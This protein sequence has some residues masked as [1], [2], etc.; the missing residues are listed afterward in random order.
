M[1]QTTVTK[2]VGY[3]VRQAWL[4]TESDPLDARK[5]S[6]KITPEGLGVVIR[7]YGKLTPVIDQVFAS[8]SDQQVDELK[9]GL[10]RLNTHKAG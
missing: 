7:A 4:S 9:Q 5:K 1:N 8:L 2:I 10:E 3:L 6:L